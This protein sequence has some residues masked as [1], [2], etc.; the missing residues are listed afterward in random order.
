MFDVTSGDVKV[1]L[2]TSYS[3]VAQVF[4]SAPSGDV[5]DAHP[6][7][8]LLGLTLLDNLTSDLILLSQTYKS[9]MIYMGKDLRWEF[10]SSPD[11]AVAPYLLVANV[12]HGSTKLCVVGVKRI[13]ANEDVKD[14]FT[15]DW[16]LNYATALT[17]IAEGTILRKSGIIDIKNDG[18]E[19]VSEGKEEKVTLEEELS[20]NGRHL[21][22]VQRI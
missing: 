6:W 3:T 18:P 8:A 22:F 19:M 17:R 4:P 13:N 10:I 14:E 11:P 1:L 15:L 5:M 2:N 16:I 12:P 7:K 21:A 9:Y 20:I